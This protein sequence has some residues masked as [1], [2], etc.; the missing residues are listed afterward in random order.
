[1][2][3][4]SRRAMRMADLVRQEL[5]LLLEHEVNDPRVGFATVV[6]VEMS[7]DLQHAH[8]WISAPGNPEQR[9]QSLEG[10]QAAQNF[11]RYQLTRRLGLRHAPALSFHLDQTPGEESGIEEMLRRARTKSPG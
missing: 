1:M 8:I 4:R 7:P 10:L 3:D 6:S 11:L 9:K 5:G 2:N